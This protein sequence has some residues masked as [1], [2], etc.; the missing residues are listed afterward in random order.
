[1]ADVDRDGQNI[2]H[3]LEELACLG[4]VAGYL[5]R[6]HAEAISTPVEPQVVAPPLLVPE[7][8]QG[9]IPLDHLPVR[10][11]EEEVLQALDL[12]PAA[13][14]E[15][16]GAERD[17][18]PGEADDRPGEHRHQA[19]LA[20]TLLQEYFLDLLLQRL[21]SGQTEL[22]LREHAPHGLLGLAAFPVHL[23][24]LAA[25]V[26]DEDPASVGAVDEADVVLVNPHCSVGR[27]HGGLLV[28]IALVARWVVGIWWTKEKTDTLS[29]VHQTVSKNSAYYSEKHGVSRVWA[30]IDSEVFLAYA[31][32]AMNGQ[33]RKHIRP[34]LAVDIVLKKD[35]PTGRL[36]RGIVQDI[37]TSSPEHHRGIKVRLTSGQVGRVQHIISS[38]A[39][40]EPR[41][42]KICIDLWVDIVCPF[43]YIGERQLELALEQF[44][45]KDSVE[46]MIHSFE[47]DPQA[48]ASVNKTLHEYLAERKGVSVD[49]AKQMNEQVNEYAASVGL[50]FDLDAAK[51]ANSFDAHRLVHLASD[52]DLG[53]QMMR[54]LHAAYFSEGM[55]IADR[56]S[57]KK[58]TTEVGIESSAVETMFATSGYTDEVRDDER[59]AAEI[60]VTGVPFFLINNKYSI[61]GAQSSEAFLEG[62]RR[63]WALEFESE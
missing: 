42:Q 35:Q 59:T 27:G 1:M 48:P 12:A 61:T 23:A 36:T 62:L 52:Y 43:C 6:R 29:F 51:P 5:R 7:G 54:R 53:T 44:E 9:D 39:P 20:A 13:V 16:R 57:L 25:V 47:L 55:D 4:G 19:L 28:C 46:V 38:E 22:P 49:E 8:E 58:L 45:Y 34:G 41:K 2:R 40:A 14:L 32:Y 24:P 18:G 21:G 56:E 10:F 33:T 15:D 11:R 31:S 26:V 3:G 60:S 17:R 50:T 63:V 30:E 37:L